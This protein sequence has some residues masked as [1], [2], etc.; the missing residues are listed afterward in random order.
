M[1]QPKIDHHENVIIGAG[2]VGAGIFRDLSLHS[3]NVLMVE[4]FDFASQTSQGSSKMLHGGI[5]YLEN[6][7]FFLVFEA[8]RE[9][10]LWLKMAPHIAKEAHFYLPVYKE[11]KWPYLFLLRIG[12]FIYNLLSLFKNPPYQILNRK[13]TIAALPDIKQEGLRG[14]GVYW[15]GIVDDS[16]LAIDC[17]LDALAR[18]P[19]ATALNYTELIKVERKNENYSLSLLNTITNEIKDVTC[20]NLIFATGP[21]IDQVMQ[22]LDIAWD[23]II[24][25][26]KG[27]HLWVKRDS[28]PIESPMVLQ[29]KDNRIIFV[30]PQRNAILV[31]TTEVPLE[32]DDNFFN[33]TPLQSEIDYLIHALNE[34]F[35]KSD[36]SK[37]HILSTFA[38]VRPLVKCN[39]KDSSGKTS[40][41]HMVYTPQE[42]MWVIAGGKYT[43]FRVM[44]QDI[45]KRVLK[46][47]GKTYHKKLSLTPLTKTSLVKDIFEDSSS[48]TITEEVLERVF[49]EEMPA[50]Y[51]DFLTR[52]LSIP[53]IEQLDNDE[54][55]AKIE[56]YKDRF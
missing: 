35:P 15:D 5:R 9:K 28:L 38:A 18:N 26:S 33:I 44:A 3:E 16:K 17:I 43:T 2:I 4:K 1:G 29:T 54:L 32:T 46:K 23:G 25:P 31:G 34:Y 41:K 13:K 48:G 6:L 40:R 11:S 10:K 24:L 47:N 14:A 36:I 37:E 20:K 49:Q 8:L 22:K 21:F 50:N 19:N 53:S 39:S 52:R 56:K 7:D 55:K 27:S 45:C 42:N 30:I 12:L 51:Q